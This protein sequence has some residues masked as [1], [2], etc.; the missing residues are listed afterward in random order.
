M[1]QVSVV[2]FGFARSLLLAVEINSGWKD[3]R[4]PRCYE[5][6][7]C[8][9]ETAKHSRQHWPISS[10][11]R[12]P[13][14]CEQTAQE[15]RHVPLFAK[16]DIR[17]LNP[18]RHKWRHRKSSTLEMW[19]QHGRMNFVLLS[20]QLRLF[21]IAWRGC[22]KRR[23]QRSKLGTFAS[24]FSL[25]NLKPSRYTMAAKGNSSATRENV[26]NSGKGSKGV[27]KRGHL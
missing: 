13:A 1:R 19:Q 3:G 26:V 25:Y 14:A 16:T 18:W 20:V 5:P 22:I 23:E 15:R 21:T 10:W 7:P 11:R 9:F 8:H 12:K 4:N 17:C 27:G 24:Q 6:S 2:L